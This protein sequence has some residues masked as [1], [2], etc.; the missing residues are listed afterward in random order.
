MR[1]RQCVEDERGGHQVCASAK[2]TQAITTRPAMSQTSRVIRVCLIWPL[3]LRHVEAF[4]VHA[5][6]G[7]VECDES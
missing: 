2:T 5:L 3:A 7:H 4:G 6:R 1:R